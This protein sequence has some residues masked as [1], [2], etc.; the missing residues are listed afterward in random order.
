MNKILTKIT[1][2][3]MVSFLLFLL[4]SLTLL[5]QTPTTF[6]YQAALR[7]ATGHILESSNVSIQL[8]IHQ[9][10]ETGTIV[11]SEVHNT[12][13]NEFGLVNLEIGSVTPA[14]FATIDWAAGPYFIE[15]IVEGTTMGVSELLTVPYALYAVNGV[16]G[17][18]GDPG[19]Q[20]PQG[21]PGPQGPPGEITE[22]SVESIHVVNNSL[23]A[24]D[25]DAGSVG[26]SEV[27]NNSLTADDLASGSVGSDEVIDNSLVAADI[28]P[29]AIGTSE[30][31]DNSV[32]SSN[33]IVNSLVAADI[34]PDA[35]GASELAN[36]SVA[37][38]NV[39]DNSLTAADLAPNSVGSS[40]VTDNSLY[41]VDIHDE[42]GIEWVNIS[43]TNL[44]VTSA[45]NVGV[46]TMTCPTSGY[47]LVTFAGQCHAD[48]GDRIVLAA[49]DASADWGPN[50]GAVTVYGTHGRSKS[51][52]HTRVYSVSEGTNTFYAVVHN[53]VDTAGDG[54]ASVYATLTAQFYPTRY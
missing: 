2:L 17:P 29:D 15:V 25:L 54:R 27:A 35:I 50:D 20:G 6:N 22:N 13:T 14:S 30:L 19:A 49:S 26:S 44:L 38:A 39:V 18:Q 31:A 12:S 11:Y 9:S 48:I 46:V 33:V 53:Y 4:S 32:G 8:V 45:Q 42:A 1:R 36:N 40:E 5:G 34:A 43:V 10:T 16:P 23:T 3:G 41:D 21:D 51:F 52:C 7:D 24:D 28:A 37:S 47:V